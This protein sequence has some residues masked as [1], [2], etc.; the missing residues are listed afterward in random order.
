MMLVLSNQKHNSW[1]DFT[2]KAI[3][4]TKKEMNEIVEIK[5]SMPS[6]LYEKGKRE[7]HYKTY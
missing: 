7:Q 5:K 1:M 2:M 6:D 4:R 3:E